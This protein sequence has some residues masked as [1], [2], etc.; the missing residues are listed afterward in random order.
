MRLLATQPE[1]QVH[2]TPPPTFSPEHKAPA[3]QA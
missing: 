3:P 1:P 2:R